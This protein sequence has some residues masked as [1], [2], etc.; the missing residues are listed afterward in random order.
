[1]TLYEPEELELAA[2][3]AKFLNQHRDTLP[4]EWRDDE[5][6]RATFLHDGEETGVVVRKDAMG[7]YVVEAR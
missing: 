3:V 1:M 5:E 4:E 7:V 2:K 6:V